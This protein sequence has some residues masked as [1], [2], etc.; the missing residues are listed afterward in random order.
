MNVVYIK[1]LYAHRTQMQNTIRSVSRLRKE[2]VTLDTLSCNV[3]TV[4][5]GVHMCVDKI[6]RSRTRDIVWLRVKY[7]FI[8]QLA[9]C[10][11]SRGQKQPIVQAKLLTAITRHDVDLQ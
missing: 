5:V 9:L 4:Y 10:S 1:T 7:P 8:I 11:L 2:N 6:E 3:N